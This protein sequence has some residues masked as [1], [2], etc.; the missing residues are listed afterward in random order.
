[1]FLVL[2]AKISISVEQLLN[3]VKQVRGNIIKVKA[4]VFCQNRRLFYY[5]LT[6]ESLL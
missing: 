6:I 2:C 5:I 1:M 4:R 3:E